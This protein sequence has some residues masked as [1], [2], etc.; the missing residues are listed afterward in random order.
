MKALGMYLLFVIATA[1]G[2][3]VH[4]NPVPDG[5]P[6][7]DEPRKEPDGG[8]GEAPGEIKKLGMSDVSMILSR[9]RAFEF[10][11]IDGIDGARDLVPRDLYNR[12]A[13]AHR[14]LAY[15][16]GD[17]IIFAVRFDLC[18]RVVPGPCPEGVDGSLRLVFQPL[19]PPLEAADAGLHAFYAIP[20]AEL[21]YMVS[22]LRAIARIA[23]TSPIEPLGE[24][25]QL[26]T[27]FQRLRALLDRYA[28]ADKLIRLSAMGQD[29]RSPQP[30]V[31]F[32]GV[33]LRDGAMVD[34]IVATTEAT[35]QVA[36][37]TGSGS[38]YEVTPLVD[39]PAGFALAMQAS[40]FGAAT[41]AEQRAA[42]DALVATQNP[43]LHTAATAQCASCHT[44]THLAVQ[45][46]VSAG[47]DV[48]SLPSYFTTTRDS[49]L[50]KGISV[51]DNRSLHGFGWFGQDLAISQR[52]ANETAIVL[53]E[54]EKRFPVPAQ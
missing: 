18:D 34:M 49:R 1:C 6:G 13:T 51:R 45:R 19:I 20:A 5:G 3:G 37:L 41:P 43:M 39:Q 9:I 17:F 36:A 42:L 11:R 48:S 32:R 14:D 26:L 35:E 30:R 40:A 53:D 25:S 52:V 23:P 24:E 27:A 54:I 31:V 7:D 38:T 47:I 50:L 29:L 44:S 10:G 28:R 4:S 21:G 2:P 12:V 33:E 16:F 22:E 8:S 46:A 15:N